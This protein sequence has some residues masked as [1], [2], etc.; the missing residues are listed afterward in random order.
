MRYLLFSLAALFSVSLFAQSMVDLFVESPTPVYFFGNDYTHVKLIGPFSQFAEAGQAGPQ[1]VKE[2][3][4]EA[5]NYFYLTEADKY[6]PAEVFRKPNINVDIQPLLKLNKT[7]P[8][9][10]MEASA[11]PNYTPGQIAAFTKKY[12]FGVKSGIG[13]VLLAE[14]LNK[15]TEQGVYHVIFINLADNSVL[16]SE[17]MAG[18]VGGFGLRNY[19]AKSFYNVLQDIKSK[20]WKEWKKMFAPTK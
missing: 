2:K 11:E 20:K 15:V 18:S 9:E 10:E 7:T 6:N 12:D 3:Y 5:W 1:L 16:Y 19:Y 13:I 4:F 14:A 17:R 8:V